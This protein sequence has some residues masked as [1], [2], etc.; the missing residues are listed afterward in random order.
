[1]KRVFI[2]VFLFSNNIMRPYSQRYRNFSSCFKQALLIS[3]SFCFIGYFSYLNTITVI[4]IPQHIQKINFLPKSSGIN[5][6]LLTNAN[7]TF[8]IRK[9][10]NR[11]L[12]TV[13]ISLKLLI[14]VFNISSLGKV[15]HYHFNPWNCSKRFFH[16]PSNGI[17]KKKNISFQ[18]IAILL[19]SVAN[20]DKLR[21]NYLPP[22]TAT[23]AGGANFLLAPGPSSTYIP[24]PV[25]EPAF[26]RTGKFSTCRYFGNLVKV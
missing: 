1:M 6:Y 16:I 10:Q 14:L 5:E 9:F 25:P 4:S 24:A 21:S 12:N 22:H 7:L 26:T 2:Q 3:V 15:I 18:F 17:Y 20:A 19:T 23:T 13:N 8:K 11:V